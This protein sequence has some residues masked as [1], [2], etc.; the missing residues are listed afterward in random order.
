MKDAFNNT[1]LRYL[2]LAFH[3]EREGQAALL[4]HPNF[5]EGVKAFQDKRPPTF[6]K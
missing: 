1:A 5:A 3:L 4:A 6:T 2:D